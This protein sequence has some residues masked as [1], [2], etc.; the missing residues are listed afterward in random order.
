MKAVH[1]SEKDKQSVENILQ[2]E[3]QQRL[4]KTMKLYGISEVGM[5]A[6]LQMITSE[7]GRRYHQALENKQKSAAR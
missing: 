7:E 6:R 1:S 4:H 2:D 5:E 3:D